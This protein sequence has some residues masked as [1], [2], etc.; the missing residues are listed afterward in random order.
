MWDKWHSSR[1]SRRRREWNRKSVQRNKRQVY[2]DW[3]CPIC[4]ILLC[5]LWLHKLWNVD[6]F[7]FLCFSGLAHHCPHCFRWYCGV[8]SIIRAS[9]IFT[10]IFFTFAHIRTMLMLIPVDRRKFNIAHLK[11]WN[12]EKWKDERGLPQYLNSV[13]HQAASSKVLRLTASG[14]NSSTSVTTQMQDGVFQLVKASEWAATTAQRHSDVQT[15]QCV[16]LH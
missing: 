6:E 14:S 8:W 4:Y 15:A 7:F 16:L 3:T 11:V 12:A 10:F 5:K 9:Q 13:F 1:R 2:S